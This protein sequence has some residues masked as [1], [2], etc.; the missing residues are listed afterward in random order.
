[1]RIQI[2]GVSKLDKNDFR[3]Y[4]I[5]D[6]GERT[7]LDIKPEDLQN[8]LNPLQVLIII[9]DDL[10][11]IYIWKGVNSHVRKKFIASRIAAELQ[12][13]LV[14]NGHFHRCK[15]ISVDQGDE[16]QEFLDAFGLESMELPERDVERTR[17]MLRA[18]QNRTRK[19]DKD[20]RFPYP[21]VFKPPSP[22]DDLALA[23]RTQ[24]RQPPKKKDTKEKINCQYCGKELT[25]E[26]QLTHSCKKKPEKNNKL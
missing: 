18:F 1:L 5:Q 24:L 10:R 20:D 11:R 15:I 26:E 16:L 8:Y 13:D 21:Y 2:E 4:E 25:E 22:P 9:R 14:V 6:T 23:P 3:I 12:N 7:K 17:E 19:R